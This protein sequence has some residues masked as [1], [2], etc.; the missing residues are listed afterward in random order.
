MVPYLNLSL[1][2]RFLIG[3]RG[4]PTASDIGESVR[5]TQYVG[6]ATIP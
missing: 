5:K 4:L 1:W 3:R 2:R 6:N